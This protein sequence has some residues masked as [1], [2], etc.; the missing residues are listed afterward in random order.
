MWR[1]CRKHENLILIFGLLTI[2]FSCTKQPRRDIY[3][4][5]SL[6]YYYALL[7]FSIDSSCYQPGNFLLVTASFKTQSDSTFW[8]S[9]NNLND[10]LFV[11]VDSVSKDNFF[12]YHLSKSCAAD[13]GS[14]LLK[15]KDFFKQQFGNDSVPFFSKN[16]SVVKINYKVTRILSAET[17]ENMAIN[18]RKEELQQIETYFASPSQLEQAKDTLE[19]YWIDRP[20]PSS[21]PLIY[22]GDLVT[23]SYQGS[24]LDG[25]FFEKSTTDFE[26]IYGTP[27][28][29][30]N[31]LNIVIG[32][33]KFG[34]TAKILLSSRLAFGAAGSSNGMV[35][36]YTPLIYELKIIDVKKIK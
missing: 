4:Q 31:G 25:R 3:T 1:F 36:P 33:L 7:S 29:I 34:Q 15:T 6:G 22:Y 5:H 12:N 18:L 20:E 10:K 32:K 24:F 19:F 13:S 11:R 2:I 14:L 9:R 28:Q 26:F 35:P 23:F 27:D 30:L 21:L 8:D 17:L 16:D